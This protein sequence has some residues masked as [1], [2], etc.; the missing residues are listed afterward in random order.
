MDEGACNGPSQDSH[1]LKCQNHHRNK[2]NWWRSNEESLNK[3]ENVRC[4]RMN[5]QKCILY[6]LLCL[7]KI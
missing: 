3:V 5:K 6:V 2:T 1:E 4:K 7:L